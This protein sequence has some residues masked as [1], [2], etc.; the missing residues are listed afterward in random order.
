MEKTSDLLSFV[1][2]FLKDIRNIFLCS[3]QNKKVTL[4]SLVELKKPLKHLPEA[5]VP[6]AFLALSKFNLG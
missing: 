1:A 2:I 4:E 5:C 6:T 3:C